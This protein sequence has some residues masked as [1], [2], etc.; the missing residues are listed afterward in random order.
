MHEI[1]H[2]YLC[3]DED[4]LT[5]WLNER[6]EA[7]RQNCAV[8][9]AARSALRVLPIAVDGFQFSDWSRQ[10]DVTAMPIWRSLL[11]SSVSAKLPA[12]EVKANAAAATSGAARLVTA[13]MPTAARLDPSVRPT[14]ARLN[15]ARPAAVNAASKAANA[16]AS[17]NAANSAAAAAAAAFAATD[18][19]AVWRNVRADCVTWVD[20]A[21]S[22]GT[23]GIDVAP[24]NEGEFNISPDWPV[25]REKLL[26]DTDP[27]RGADW[28]FWVEWYDKILRG[29]PQD[30]DML[31]EIAISQDIDWEATPRE[32]N[33]AIARIV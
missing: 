27:D 6:P 26:N 25:V 30:W 22:D 21:A 9:I 31:Y 16:A 12:E 33:A 24:L 19:D 11:I 5:A 3:K 8:F 17:A 20:H 28:S 1:G 2:E 7:V 23:C 29:D 14:L 15:F 32:V 10:R 13:S 4:S 18:A